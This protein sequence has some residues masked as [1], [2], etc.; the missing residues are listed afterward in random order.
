MMETNKGFPAHIQKLLKEKGYYDLTNEERLE[1]H[2]DT[3]EN[4]KKVP[5]FNYLAGREALKELRGE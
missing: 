2:K 4:L 5:H 1:K 3:I